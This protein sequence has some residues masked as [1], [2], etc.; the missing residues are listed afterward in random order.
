MAFQF[1]PG[2]SCRTARGQVGSGRIGGAKFS[3]RTAPGSRRCWK[4]SRRI[5]AAA[6]RSVASITLRDGQ[7]RPPKRHSRARSLASSR[8]LVIIDGWEQ[9]SWLSR[10]LVRWRCRRASAGLLVTSHAR[11]RLADSSFARNPRA[12]WS[13][14]SCPRSPVEIRRRSPTPTSLLAMPAVAATCASFFSPFTTATSNSPPPQGPPRKPPQ[15]GPR[16]DSGSG[17]RASPGVRICRRDKSAIKVTVL[18]R[19]RCCSFPSCPGGACD[20]SSTATTCRPRRGLEF[21]YSRVDPALFQDGN[22]SGPRS[23]CRSD[24]GTACLA[25]RVCRK[26]RGCPTRFLCQFAKSSWQMIAFH[27]SQD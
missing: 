4:R 22:P 9:L 26:V 14:N 13:T 17:I 19:K 11:D 15:T 8:P 10:L 16:N 25:G 24:A 21:T 5:I 3:A 12:S 23:R 7:R 27:P 18:R 1:P 2:E 6:G 20:I